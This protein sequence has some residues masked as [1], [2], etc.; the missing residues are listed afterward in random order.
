MRIAIILFSFVIIF[1]PHIT[2]QDYRPHRGPHRKQPHFSANS[3]SDDD[4]D[5]SSGDFDP[6]I[7][8]SIEDPPL[9]DSS[10]ND[11]DD[12]DRNEV[13]VDLVE[14]KDSS[15][16]FVPIQ[17]DELVDESR[18]RSDSNELKTPSTQPTL[19]ESALSPTNLTSEPVTPA[20]DELQTI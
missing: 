14:S 1:A 3:D 19:I 4:S 12:E 6:R 10:A 18:I 16:E 8:M 5:I 20:L 17:S 11:S 15:E 2:A 7:Y 13:N 9:Q